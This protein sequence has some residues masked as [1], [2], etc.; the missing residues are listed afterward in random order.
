MV[1]E[2]ILKCLA[3]LLFYYNIPNF[4]GLLKLSSHCIT[5]SYATYL[6]PNCIW[7]IG[8]LDPSVG[9]YVNPC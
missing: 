1:G 3:L 7:A 9:S 8:F 6:T 4:F 5:R 2:A